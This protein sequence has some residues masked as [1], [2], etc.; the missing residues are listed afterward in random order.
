MIA[1]LADDWSNKAVPDSCMQ[2]YTLML[3]G[4]LTMMMVMIADLT[5]DRSNKAV[6]GTYI[7]YI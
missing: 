3:R 5:D 7:P 6:P 4:K 2:F 1:D